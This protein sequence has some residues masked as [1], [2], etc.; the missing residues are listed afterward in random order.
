MEIAT[1]ERE[2]NTAVYALFSLTPEEI[3]L[4]EHP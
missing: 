2:I 3:A 1:H 4:I